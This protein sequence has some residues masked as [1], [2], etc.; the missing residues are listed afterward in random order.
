MDIAYINPNISII[1]MNV[2]GPN[3]P[4]KRDCQMRLKKKKDPP[5]CCPQ[6]TQMKGKDI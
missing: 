3:E 5:I 2:K 1:I 4:I 6:K